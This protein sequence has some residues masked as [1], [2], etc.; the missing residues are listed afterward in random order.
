MDD[1]SKDFMIDTAMSSILVFKEA[2][3]IVNFKHP[4]KSKRLSP[5][6]KI[7]YFTDLINEEHKRVF[8][9]YNECMKNNKKS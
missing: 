5:T 7:K 6:Q 2:I 8:D 3:D 9:E 1:L 4:D